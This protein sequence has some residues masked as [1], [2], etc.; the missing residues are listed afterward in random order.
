MGKL[1]QYAAYFRCRRAADRQPFVDGFGKCY[2]G[3]IV[4][5]EN[6]LPPHCSYQCGSRFIIGSC[7]VGRR[8]NLGLKLFLGPAAIIDQVQPGIYT[9]ALICFRTKLGNP[10]I[11]LPRQLQ[12]LISHYNCLAHSFKT[13]PDPIDT[14]GMAAHP[15]QF[16]VQFIYRVLRHIRV[17][18]K[19]FQGSAQFRHFGDAVCFLHHIYHPVHRIYGTLNRCRGLFNKPHGRTDRCQKIPLLQR[20]LA[21]IS[22][23]SFSSAS[24]L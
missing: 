19:F 6:V 22:S 20:C 7:R 16:L 5:G 12:P 10:F 14:G 1:D 21:F 8:H 3:I 9:D 15:V 18:A 23:R 4:S 2:G 17:M 11:S 24:I 13:A